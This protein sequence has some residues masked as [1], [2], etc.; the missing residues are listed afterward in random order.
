MRLDYRKLDFPD[1]K[2]GF[3][4][5]VGSYVIGY[6]CSGFLSGGDNY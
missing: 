6:V 2:Q 4:S 3:L 5:T 1:K